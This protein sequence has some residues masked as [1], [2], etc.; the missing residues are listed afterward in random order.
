MQSYVLNVWSIASVEL[1]TACQNRR[2]R[3]RSSYTWDVEDNAAAGAERWTGNVGDGAERD[4][5]QTMHEASGIDPQSCPQD[6]CCELIADSDQIAF[7]D[8]SLPV[9][10]RLAQQPLCLPRLLF[11]A[12][13]Q[14]ADLV[15]DAATLCHQLSDLSLSMH[16]G[17]VVAIPELLPDLR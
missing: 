13:G 10:P 17:G 9:S 4:G 15:V 8:R 1:W 6:V 16:H 5:P 11:D 7:E 3:R 12:V 14:L 2:P